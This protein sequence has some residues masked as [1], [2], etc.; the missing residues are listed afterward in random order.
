MC[1]LL[2]VSSL[3]ILPQELDE[4]GVKRGHFGQE[5]R[6]RQEPM[7]REDDEQHN[8]ID[9]ELVVSE[10]EVDAQSEVHDVNENG[11][12]VESAVEQF[13]VRQ[14]DE[15]AHSLD[16]FRVFSYPFVAHRMDERHA[17]RIA[18]KHQQ[19]PKYCTRCSLQYIDDGS[20]Q[21]K[22]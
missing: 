3:E 8:H 11:G 17:L 13:E 15:A 6:V 22:F 1:L 4:S 19:K 9:E 7:R 21:K 20:S 18:V 2:Q 10:V 5:V 16:V 12:R 14:V